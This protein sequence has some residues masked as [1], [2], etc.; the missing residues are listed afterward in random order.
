MGLTSFYG[1]PVFDAVG[2]LAIGGLLGGVASFVIV[3]NAGA[4]VGKSIA[5]ASLATINRCLEADEM[6]RAI[7]DVK[8]TNMG[9]EVIRYKAE[10][11]FDGR[12]L[13]RNYLDSVDLVALQQ[14]LKEVAEAGENGNLE[15]VEEFMLKHGENIVDLLGA[16]V[17]RIEN[18]LKRKHPQVRHVDLE[19]L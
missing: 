1:M 16:E 19:V 4:L 2:S 5:P 18:E 17:D 10:V 8:A 7:H 13:T 3:S 11:D 15:S 6:V 12:K 9:N 14:E